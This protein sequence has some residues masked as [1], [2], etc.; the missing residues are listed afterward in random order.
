MKCMY[1]TIKTIQL[2]FKG[3]WNTFKNKLTIVHKK[4]PFSMETWY[5]FSSFSNLDII[6]QV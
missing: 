5:I 6:D 1:N 4:I 3:D 2:S